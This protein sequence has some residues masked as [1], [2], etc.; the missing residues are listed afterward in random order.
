MDD[1]FKTLESQVKNSFQISSAYSVDFHRD[2]YVRMLKNNVLNSETFRD[3]LYLLRTT[4][5]SEQKR[6][7]FFQKSSM[8]V[9]S[10]FLLYTN[11]DIHN[12]IFE[13]SSI[14]NLSQLLRDII[15]IIDNHIDARRLLASP[16]IMEKILETFSFTLSDSKYLDKL[17]NDSEYVEEYYRNSSNLFEYLKTLYTTHNQKSVYFYEG[18]VYVDIYSRIVSSSFSDK[19]KESILSTLHHND[20]ARKI[21][22][23]LVESN[24]F[25]SYSYTQLKSVLNKDVGKK[26]VKLNF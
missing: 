23:Q 25:D 4:P 10:E 21:I 15:D 6:N 12:E 17:L 19:Q 20:S 22:H 24:L 14:Q 8:S 7:S 26:K 3:F 13:S 1:A 9:L 18:N 2:H 11:N 16:I 5:L